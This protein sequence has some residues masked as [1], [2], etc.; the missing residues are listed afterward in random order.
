[1]LTPS[2]S[3]I[4]SARAFMPNPSRE[5]LSPPIGRTKSVAPRPSR[6]A[7]H[8]ENLKFPL[9]CSQSLTSYL[10]ASL[11]IASLSLVTEDTRLAQNEQA[12]R[13]SRLDPTLKVEHEGIKVQKAASTQYLSA[14]R[15]K[16]HTGTLRI[17]IRIC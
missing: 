13:Q 11:I 1:M 6:R 8:C 9:I 5:L 12:S 7:L 10:P 15:Q 17:R 16:L 3:P 2:I 4:C 14:I